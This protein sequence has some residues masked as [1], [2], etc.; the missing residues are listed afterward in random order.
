[1]SK[2]TKQ[3]T[4]EFIRARLGA[5]P[6]EPDPRDYLVAQL[7][8][9]MAATLPDESLTLLAYAPS[10]FPQDQGE[11]GLCGG[12]CGSSVYEMMKAL[13]TG[14]VIPAGFEDFSAGWVYEKSRDILCLPD[15]IE[16]TNNFGVVKAL[17]GYG[18][19]PEHL[20]PTD[21]DRPYKYVEL[22]GAKEAAAE[23]KIVAFYRVP[24]T[25][26]AIKAA[27]L[28][29]TLDPGYKMPDGSNGMCP[30]V[31]S[32]P[33]FKNAWADA[34]ETGIVHDVLPGDELLGY[35]AGPQ[36]GFLI[37]DGVKYLVNFGSWGKD[38]GMTLL[39]VPGVFLIPESYMLSDAYVLKMAQTGQEPETI[40]ETII[41]WIKIL[42]G[43]IF[44]GENR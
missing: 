4:T 42:I 39:G 27:M 17:L 41:R 26:S 15:Y 16:G 20:C 3:E 14:R 33:V 1:M 18:A 32:F 43:M 7:P 37:R 38:V 24:T 40:L 35:H 25:P 28:G 2:R 31:T 13:L 5:L 23:N 44:G 10:E 12:W 19:A 22:P 6:Y 21:T 8:P 11:L 36:I 9:E 29:W 30:V 34:L